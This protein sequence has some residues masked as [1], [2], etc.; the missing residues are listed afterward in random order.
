MPAQNPAT[1][2][3]SVQTPPDF[4]AAVSGLWGPMVFDLSADIFNTQSP[5]FFDKEDDAL[6]QDWTLLN[7]NLWL[8]CEYAQIDPF[9]RKAAETAPYGQTDRRIFLL[10]PAAVGT[11]WYADHVHDKARVLFL[12]PRLTF[13]GHKHPYP[14]DL[15]LALYGEQPGCEC[16]RWKQST[17]KPVTRCATP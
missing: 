11:N 5:A 14:K 16:W 17:R 10:V 6:K 12:R 13:V 3:Q 7:G 1:S 8:N 15:M 2:E 4:M 9:A